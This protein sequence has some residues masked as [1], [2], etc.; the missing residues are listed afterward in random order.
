MRIDNFPSGLSIFYVDVRPLEPLT[1]CGEIDD[2]NFGVGFNIIG[3]SK[4]RS[5]AHTQTVSID[6]G[7]SAHFISPGSTTIEEDIVTKHQLKICVLFDTKTLHGMADEDEEP[8]LPFLKGLHKQVFLNGQGKILPQMSQALTQLI[9][10]PYCGKTRA[11][12]LESKAMELL[13]YRLDQ[14]KMERALPTGLLQIKT[15]DVERMHYAAELLACTPANPPD[16]NTLAARVGM[17]R[18]KFYQCFK[19][20]YGH[21]P[22]D[23]L[24]SQ[25]LRVAK[26]LLQQGNHNVTEAAYAVGYN[27]PGYFT[28]VFNAEFGI[29]PSQII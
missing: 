26:D 25:R 3:H 6:P 13:A 27:S 15:I 5:S 14:L 19:A 23:H 9:A 22:L 11:L 24:R 8:F 28:R 17:S 29:H 18:S 7:V 21:S 2:W 20:V 1:F 10:C 4:S 16:I 12:F